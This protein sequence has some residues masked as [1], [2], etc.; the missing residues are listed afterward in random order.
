MKSKLFKVLFLVC[1]VSVLGGC[2]SSEVESESKSGVSSDEANNQ[3]TVS[4][5][6][7]KNTYFVGVGSIDKDE[8]VE[9]LYKVKD[10]KI[11]TIALINSDLTLGE[12][13]K[14]N[15]EDMESVFEDHMKSMFDEKINSNKAVLSRFESEADS[16]SKY[17]DNFASEYGDTVLLAKDKFNEYMN[18]INDIGE[19]RPYDYMLTL[20]TDST[21]NRVDHE[22][23]EFDRDVFNLGINS[24][25][26]GN[27]GEVGF[28]ENTDMEFNI[29]ASASSRI[30]DSYFSGFRTDDDFYILAKTDKE[31]FVDFDSVDSDA[32]NITVDGE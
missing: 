23:L 25:F 18:F 20:V 22:I 3:T 27:Y 29:F 26:A 7:E 19:F 6:L 16:E 32:D 9:S 31:V 1:F 2:G 15:D 11:A 21:G 8:V 28:K 10:G 12:L 13:S 4:G 5:F 17:K 30:Y 24:E 14:M